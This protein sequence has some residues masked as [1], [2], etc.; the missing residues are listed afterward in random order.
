MDGLLNEKA[1]FHVEYIK[2]PNNIDEAA[3][4]VINFLETKRSTHRM[5]SEHQH[6]HSTRMVRPADDSDSESESDVVKKPVHSVRK[7]PDQKPAKS[8]TPKEQKPER[9]QSEGEHIDTMDHRMNCL[10]RIVQELKA[11]KTGRIWCKP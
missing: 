8:M 3:Y 2:G 9:G 7:L 5:G 1:S 6:K 4:E 10:E 11:E